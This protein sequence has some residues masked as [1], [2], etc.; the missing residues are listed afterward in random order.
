M[1]D[2]QWLAIGRKPLEFRK[3]DIV[4]R[5]QEEFFE[6]REVSDNGKTFLVNNNTN[7]VKRYFRFNRY[8]CDLICPVERRLDFKEMM[9]DE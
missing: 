3:G 8:H 9:G 4:R 5:F 6:I 2:E 1:T 7:R